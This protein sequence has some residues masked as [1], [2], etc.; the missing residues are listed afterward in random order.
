[1][2]RRRPGQSP[3]PV[4]RS[5]SFPNAGCTPR[6]CQK[7]FNFFC[8]EVSD[9]AVAKNDP[10]RMGKILEEKIYSHQMAM[11]DECATWAERALLGEDLD[12][13]E[14]AP[15]S[16]GYHEVDLLVAPR[17]L[18]GANGWHGANE[19]E[20]NRVPMYDVLLT[21]YLRQNP[22]AA[23]RR[24]GL[25]PEARPRDTYSYPVDMRWPSCYGVLGSGPCSDLA[26]T[27][28]RAHLLALG[29]LRA[30]WKCRILDIAMEKN[31]TGHYHLEAKCWILRVRVD[32][33]RKR[34]YR[35]PEEPDENP[36]AAYRRRV[37][38]V[39]S[40]YM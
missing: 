23:G 12:K 38:G 27:R 20:L 10:Q 14:W 36:T 5:S 25:R 19:S 15:F 2:P 18:T 40:V 34:K 17:Q 9:V 30:E 13:T 39:P 1:M 31:G 33:N 16:W 28:V 21:D 35:A 6:A 22:G 4:R 26:R 3:P 11:A 32:I 29:G 7:F 8:F 24:F 37:L